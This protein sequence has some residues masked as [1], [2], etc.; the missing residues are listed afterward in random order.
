[1]LE[2][3]IVLLVVAGVLAVLGISFAVDVGK[4]VGPAGQLAT[5]D[6]IDPSRTYTFLRVRGRGVAIFITVLTFLLAAGALVGA[7]VM[8]AMNHH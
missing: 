3:A 2:G 1:M 4:N 8:L 7:I 5:V 6:S